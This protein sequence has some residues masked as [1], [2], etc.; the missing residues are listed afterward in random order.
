[1]L[2]LERTSKIFGK[3]VG[4]YKLYFARKEKYI[5]FETAISYYK[6]L[7]SKFK[8]Y[9][10]KREELA[11]KIGR[12]AAKDIK[13]TFGPSILKQLKSIKDS[14]ISRIYLE[15]FKSFYSAYDIFQPNIEIS[16]LTI[17]QEGKSATYRFKNSI[18]LENTD[19]FIYHIYIMCGIS[20]GILNRALKTEVLCN[21][22]QIYISDNKDESFFDINIKIK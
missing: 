11:K 12:E 4:A 7:L 22:D 16:I 5:P 3:K 2:S 8:K 15:S 18:F 21:I 14:P 10:P 19:D 13:F 20:E 17:D 6:A 1:V 9:I